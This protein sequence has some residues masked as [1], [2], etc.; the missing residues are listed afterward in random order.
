MSK[1]YTPLFFIKWVVLIVGISI[2]VGVIYHNK[3]Y[4]PIVCV[5]DGVQDYD[6]AQ[7]KQQI[8]DLFK[9]DHYWL[10]VN[11]DHDF[12]HMLDTHSPNRFETRY[13]GI[14]PIKVIRQDGQVVAW[15]AYYMRSMYEG[16]FLFMSVHPEYRKRGFGR[17]LTQFAEC[18]LRRQG[19]YKM[20][21]ATRTTNKAALAAYDRMEFTRVAETD[22]FVHYEKKLK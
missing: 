22:G 9:A 13:F 10:T 1:K 15:C 17:K 12:D 11:I 18:D 4:Q 2:A 8:I 14:M 7:D 20:T 16:K 5:V 6:P 21:L 19:A 3:M